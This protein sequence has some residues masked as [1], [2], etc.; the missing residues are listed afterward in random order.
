VIPL[1]LIGLGLLAWAMWGGA[2]LFVGI[3]GVLVIG[4]GVALRDG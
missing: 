4:A 3:I 2:P 1:V